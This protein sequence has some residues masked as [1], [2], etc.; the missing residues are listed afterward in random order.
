M[1]TKTI[2]LVLLYGRKFIVLELL[3][4]YEFAI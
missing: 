1:E 2:F 4:K 3:A